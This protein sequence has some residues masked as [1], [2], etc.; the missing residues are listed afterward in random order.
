MDCRIV[1]Y[2]AKKTSFCERS[3]KKSF[4]ELGATHGGTF[5]AT[6]TVS[7]GNQL[8]EGFRTSDLVFVVGGL[9]FDDFRSV[10]KIVSRAVSDTELDDYKKL[11]NP[12]GKD[13][14]VLRAQ[15]QILVL[16]PDN[17]QQIEQIMQGNISNYIKIYDK[18]EV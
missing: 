7:L 18:V 1:F 9:G 4:S 13:G 17:P 5:F 12:D 8:I 10:K 14:Y 15:N 6:N 3:L 16:L 11:E 2:F